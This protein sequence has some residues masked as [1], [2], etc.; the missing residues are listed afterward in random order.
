MYNIDMY[1]GLGVL[2][3]FLVLVMVFLVT[4]LFGAPYVPSIEEE[5][6]AA[7]GELRPLGKRDV[8]VDFGC[9]DGMVLRAAVKAGAGRAVGLEINPILA[10]VARLKS[11]GEKKV[12][13]KFGDMTRVKLPADMTVVYVF[14]LDRVMKMLVPVLKKFAAEQGR[15]IDV[16]SKAFEFEG[17]RPITKT[18]SHYLYRIEPNDADGLYKY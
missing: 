12:E 11:R 15:S 7:F 3:V 6:G 13:V 18:H 1:V 17:M 5:L 14:G 8:L 9:G 2:I 4:A 16:I 10:V